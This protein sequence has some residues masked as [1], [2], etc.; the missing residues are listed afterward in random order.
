MTESGAK[1]FRDLPPSAKLVFKTLEYA[2]GEL[3]QQDIVVRSRLSY[4]QT[5][6]RWSRFVQP[7]VVA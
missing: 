7:G 4:V 6:D 5:E 1:Q 2:D 3:T